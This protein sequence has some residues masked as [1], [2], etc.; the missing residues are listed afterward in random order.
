VSDRLAATVAAAWAR[1]AQV[2]ACGL[3]TI[4]GRIC[5]GART[6]D[7]ERWKLATLAP[8]LRTAETVTLAIDRHHSKSER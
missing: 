1:V 6:D 7:G 4:G 3:A 2:W 8:D 5:L